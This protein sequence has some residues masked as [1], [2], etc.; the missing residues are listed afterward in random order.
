MASDSDINKVQSIILDEV[1]TITDSSMLDRLFMSKIKNLESPKILDPSVVEITE[2][3]IDV[4]TKI[5]QIIDDQN[6][7]YYLAVSNKED[8]INNDFIYKCKFN[9]EDDII[10]L[11][12]IDYALYKNKDYCIWIEDSKFNQISNATTFTM[13]VDG[14]ID[15]RAIFEYE[16][17]PLLNQI[18]TAL[19]PYLPTTIYETLCSYIEYNE[20][21]TKNN[22]V[23]TA[24]EYILYSG[25]GQ[26]VII[27]CLK[28]IKNLIGCIS[29][30]DDIISNIDYSNKILSFDS[31]KD[32]NTLT[33]SFNED[34][35]EYQVQKGTIVN[36][37]DIDSDYVIVVGLSSDLLYKTAIMF[38][39][40]NANKM[41][42]L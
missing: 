35:V 2:E 17:N 14:N 13:N 4:E 24:I 28:A 41:E 33:I 11:E 25:L 3:Y 36:I 37:E 9:S 42:V 27:N 34:D 21:T 38:I 12:D 20:D 23:D 26:T 29:D 39:D 22:I 5:S 10:R 32:V 8:I 31:S 18:K 15:D 40:K 7:Y 1:T 16:I 30:S 6:E 19:S